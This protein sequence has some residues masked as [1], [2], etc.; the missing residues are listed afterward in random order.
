MSEGTAFAVIKFPFPWPVPIRQLLWSTK[1]ESRSIQIHASPTGGLLLDVLDDGRPSV[2]FES[3]PIIVR[4]A[5]FALLSITWKETSTSLRLN[6]EE[7]LPSIM[8]GGRSHEVS[9]TDHIPALE[10]AFLHA[11]ARALCEPW[12]AWRKTRYGVAKTVAKPNRRLKSEAEQFEELRMSNRCL[13]D[14]AG[15]V[16]N[17]NAHL[18]GHLATELRALLYWRDSK[19]SSYSPL[20]IRLAGRLN[21]PLP[22]YQIPEGSPVPDIVLEASFRVRSGEPSLI[23]DIPSKELVDIQEWLRRVVI[24]VDFSEQLADGVAAHRLSLTGK[25]VILDMATTRGSAH[26]DEDVPKALEALYSMH[27]PERDQLTRFLL[28]TANITRALN[29]YIIGSAEGRGSPSY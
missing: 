2:S 3:Q 23:K 22:I 16:A 20:L 19:A 14:L 15:A 9:T 25:E 4:G 1:H 7:V 26:Y 27:G 21:L 17:G 24:D 28:E 8:A 11:D 18:T 6:G 13:T 12:V 5:G 29:E 10:P